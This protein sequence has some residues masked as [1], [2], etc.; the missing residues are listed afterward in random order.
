MPIRRWCTPALFLLL[1]AGCASQG[2]LVSDQL[3]HQYPLLGQAP[4]NGSYALFAAG[5]DDPLFTISLTAGQPLGFGIDETG[6]VG[7]LKI[8][9]FS[10]VAGDRHIHIDANGHYQWRRL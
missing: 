4:Q 6:T 7:D 8:Q 10:A 5:Q 2:V 9:W 1:A 3:P